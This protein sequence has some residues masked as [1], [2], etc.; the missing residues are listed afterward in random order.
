MVK[1]VLVDYIRRNKDKY[2]LGD[3][4]S[5]ASA[6]GFS[7]DDF[8]EALKELSES[9][10]ERTPRY[11]LLCSSLFG[12]A[13]ITLLLVF[14]ATP[15]L[16]KINSS[17]IFFILLLLFLGFLTGFYFL[18][19]G[20]NDSFSKRTSLVLFFSF[21]GCLLLLV[22]F[23][24]F[25]SSLIS[26]FGGDS[27]SKVFLES[28]FTSSGAD[29]F[30]LSRLATNSYADF[31][32]EE[33]ININFST[34]VWISVLTPFI[35]FGIFFVSLL[36]C[37]IA[38]W[39]FRDRLNLLKYL[40]PAHVLIT[41]SLTGVF[42]YVFYKIFL[43]LFNPR[44]FISLLRFLDTLLD[45]FITWD[46]VFGAFVFVWIGVWSWLFLKLWKH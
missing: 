20:F 25:G 4:R 35:L 39:R 34:F 30:D 11:G 42:I 9:S 8:N 10:F 32:R 13:F 24:L 45:F 6:G 17:F 27:N 1:K 26:S 21:L 22:L 40:G 28:L 3:L 14:L 2:S 33:A 41:A 44:V 37:G 7:D 5:K 43:V 16:D 18:G 15:F 46:L 12:F 31:L 29:V 38:F 19:K 23:S 36:V